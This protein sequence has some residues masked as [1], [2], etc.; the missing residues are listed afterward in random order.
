MTITYKQSLTQAVK[1][2][3]KARQEKTARGC[4]IVCLKCSNEDNH[5]LWRVNLRVGGG[6]SKHTC[7]R[8]RMVVGAIPCLSKHAVTLQDQTT[9]VLRS[10][11]VQTKG[12]FFCPDKCYAQYYNSI[13][14]KCHVIQP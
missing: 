6:I 3:M 13:T 10:Q 14:I 7:V 12:F 11:K 9:V 4:N 1:A 5:F 2:D 8:W